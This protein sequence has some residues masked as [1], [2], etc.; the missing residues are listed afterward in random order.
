[1]D[2]TRT[3][4]KEMRSGDYRIVKD[5][6]FGDLD[7]MAEC[8]GRLIAYCC[9]GE[10]AKAVCAA[11]QQAHAESAGYFDGSEVGR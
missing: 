9:D 10:A 6:V 4:E 7:Y 5:T 11:H 1:M 8:R 3:G 2:W